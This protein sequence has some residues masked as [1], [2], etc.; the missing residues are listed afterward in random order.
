M[1]DDKSETNETTLDILRK[2][3]KL[4]AAIK[5]QVK[6]SGLHRAL[7]FLKCYQLHAFIW[8]MFLMA[9]G[10]LIKQAMT[11]VIKFSSQQ[12]DHYNISAYYKSKVPA[13]A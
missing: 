1:G 5:E 8:F 9:G 10:S 2:Q 3:M 4:K 7:R 13:F 11:T 6:L 12:S